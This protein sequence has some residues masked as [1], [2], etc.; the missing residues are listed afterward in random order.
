M[1][2]ML[3]VLAAALLSGRP[4]AASS[5]DALGRERTAAS[6]PRDT[7]VWNLAAARPLDDEGRLGPRAS[8]PRVRL[9]LRTL[10]LGVPWGPAP[11]GTGPAP[12]QTVESWGRSRLGRFSGTSMLVRQLVRERVE[13]IE[14]GSVVATFAV[15]TPPPGEPVGLRAFLGSSTEL[16]LRARGRAELGGDWSRFR[17]CLNEFQEACNPRLFPQ[18]SPNLLFSVQLGGV[19]SDRLRVNVDFDQIDP[20]E[21]TN[22]I[23][24]VYEGRPGE[25]VQ[26][27]EVGDVSFRVPA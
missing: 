10:P 21:A 6:V 4:L 16:G 9:G 19:I 11:T 2:V 5:A 24:I 8:V 18:L 3:A 20:F 17:P 23:N 22:R 12:G 26:R 14:R 27:L 15:D 13:R 25:A 7:I 1:R